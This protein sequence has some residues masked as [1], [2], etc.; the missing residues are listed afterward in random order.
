[1]SRPTFIDKILCEAGSVGE[2]LAEVVQEASQVVPLHGARRLPV[3]QVQLGSAK[4]EVMGERVGVCE[5]LQLVTFVSE[6]DRQLTETSSTHL[7]NDTGF[8]ARVASECCIQRVCEPST[9]F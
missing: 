5:I 7:L 3:A 9:T 1:M 2:V 4:V 8:Y 6:D